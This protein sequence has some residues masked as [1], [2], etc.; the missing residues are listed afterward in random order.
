MKAIKL[1][2]ELEPILSEPREAGVHEDQEVWLADGSIALS[3]RSS[4]G[5]EVI[6][7]DNTV[8]KKM[9]NIYKQAK[10]TSFLPSKGVELLYLSYSSK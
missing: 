10:V 8:L 9:Q 3:K 4:N 7:K 1:H 6:D 2:K 5:S